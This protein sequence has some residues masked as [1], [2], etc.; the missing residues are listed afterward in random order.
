MKYAIAL[1]VFFSAALTQASTPSVI[2]TWTGESIC[3]GNRPACKNEVVVYR[4]EPVTNN[5]RLVTLLADKIIDGK[6][7]PMGKLEFQYDEAK[8]MLSCEFTRGQTHGLWEFKITADSMEGTGMLLP[9]KSV[10]RRVKV[11]RVKED[12]VPAAP[13]RELYGSQ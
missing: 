1:L 11:K 12:Q 13:A 4:F 10:I 5:P 2:G 9:D 7:V 3:V 6:R 8:G